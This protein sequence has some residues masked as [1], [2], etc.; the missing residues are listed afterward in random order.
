M[1]DRR[2]TRGSRHI[3]SAV[4]STRPNSSLPRPRPALN[5]TASSTPKNEGRSLKFYCAAFP[6]TV[7]TRPYHFLALKRKFQQNGL[8]H[9]MGMGRSPPTSDFPQLRI[10]GPATSGDS[11]RMVSEAGEGVWRALVLV[12]RRRTRC[13]SFLCLA[14]STTLISFSRRYSAPSTSNS[15]TRRSTTP[16]LPYAHLVFAAATF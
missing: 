16:N 9:F 4:H 5:F 3:D 14:A 10:R 7:A 11:W 1:S 8:C 6:G 12:V 13:V 2:R 15:T